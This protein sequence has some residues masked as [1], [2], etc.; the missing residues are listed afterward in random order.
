MKIL[1]GAKTSSILVLKGRMGINGFFWTRSRRIQGPFYEFRIW[2][3]EGAFLE[4][5]VRPKISLILVL[6]GHMGV[7]M[8]SSGRDLEGFKGLL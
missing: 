6:E 2:R 5:L 7:S 4:I 1:V 8:D 3:Q